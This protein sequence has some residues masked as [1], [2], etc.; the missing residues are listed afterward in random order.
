MLVYVTVIF[1]AIFA[2][3]SRE[4]TEKTLI[5][6]ARKQFTQETRRKPWRTPQHETSPYC[7]TSHFLRS[8]IP[9]IFVYHG[10]VRVIL[11][12]DCDVVVKKTIFKPEHQ[13]SFRAIPERVCDVFPKK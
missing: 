9:Y 2:M 1:F 11:K 10:C 5:F 7:S 8:V 3:I 6:R 12:N 4:M 13:K